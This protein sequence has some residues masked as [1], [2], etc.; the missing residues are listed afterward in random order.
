MNDVDKNGYF[1]RRR[2][3]ALMGGLACVPLFSG[4]APKAQPITIGLHV[5]PGYEPS[6][7]AKTMGWLDEKQVK[8]VQTG[9][10]TDSLKLLEHGE[11]DGAGLTLDEVLR[12]RENGIPLSVV[13]VCDISAGADQLLVLPG[14]KSLADL[15]G[16]RI[17]AEEGALGALMLY[18]V[19]QAAGLRIEDITPVSL[20]IDQHVDAWKRGE[21]DAIVTYEPA[22]SL[23]MGMGGNRLFDSSMIPDLIVDVLAVRSALLDNAHA[24]AVRNLVASH[25]KALKYLNTNGDDA[26]YRMA[27]RLKLPPEQVMSSFKGLVLPDLENN[28]RLL[29]TSKAVLLKSAGVIAETMSKAGILHKQADLNGLLR[30]EFLPESNHDIRD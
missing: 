5:W 1:T 16:R 22:A 24:D 12:A 19:L 17:G 21:I 27:P 30:P 7:L 6:P 9:S 2:F 3:L 13:L 11:I 23:I 15:K 26:A 29:A 8:L 14:I 25:L 20:T 28:I 10:A 4:C 18:Q